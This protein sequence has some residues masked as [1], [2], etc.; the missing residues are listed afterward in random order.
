MIVKQKLTGK[1]ENSDLLFL[2]YLIY[3]KNNNKTNKQTGH[4]VGVY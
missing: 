1:K 2:A 3:I 4:C